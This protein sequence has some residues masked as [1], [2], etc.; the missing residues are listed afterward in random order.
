MPDNNT[1]M[2]DQVLRIGYAGS[3]KGYL[4]GSEHVPGWRTIAD[5]IWT[6]RNR[7]L[8]HH[9]GS[10][11][12]LLKGVQQ[13]KQQY[14]DLTDRLKVQLWGLID[15][16][17]QQQ[18]KE[19][20]IQELVKIEGYFSKPES[21]KRLTACDVLFLP[22]ETSDDPLFI[23][24]KVFDYLRIGKPVLVLG[25][26]SDCT[27]ILEQAGLGI[28]R[29]PYDAEGIAGTLK[30]LLENKDQLPAMYQADNDYIESHFHF[31]NLAQKMAD[32]FEEVLE[33]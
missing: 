9:T 27:R 13:F 29:D 12:F 22:L 16:I 5:W 6:Y 33:P 26:G 2:N 20:S 24:G 17:N 25:P 32:V 10:G 30:E 19:F 7:T 11:Y 1:A 21:A 23:P 15:P 3:L 4:P 8:K 18:V 31:S 28:R 14:P